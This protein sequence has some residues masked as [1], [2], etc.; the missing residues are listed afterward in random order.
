[1]RRIAFVVD[2]SSTHGKVIFADDQLKL[3]EIL[4]YLFTDEVEE[5][6][7]QIRGIIKEGLRVRDKYCK[8]DVSSKASDIFEMRFIQKGKNDRIYCKEVR[9][10]KHRIIIMADLFI[11]K[12]SQHIPKEWKGRI[13]TIGGYEYEI[14]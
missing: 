5:E 3:S 1:V 10:P 12:K 2:N 6:F 8:C 14:K 4:P 13:E 7:R 9:T 11:G